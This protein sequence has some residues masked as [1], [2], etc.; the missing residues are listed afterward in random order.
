MSERDWR[1]FLRDIRESASRVVEYISGMS[2]EEFLNDPK[3]L[4]R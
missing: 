4:T 1:L 3:L 2:R